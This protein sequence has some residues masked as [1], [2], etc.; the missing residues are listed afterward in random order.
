M[1]LKFI[2]LVLVVTLWGFRGSSA[3]KKSACSSGDPGSIPGSGRFPWRRDRLPNPVFL[4][5][6]G[7]SDGK[8]SACNAGNLG[9]IPGLGRFPAGGHSNPLQYSCLE[10]RH[11]QRCLAGYSPWG[12]KELDTTEPLS[13]H[14]A[15]SHLECP[16]SSGYL[17]AQIGFFEE[18]IDPMSL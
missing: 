12:R 13:T 16:R 7:G 9:L 6:P 17:S 14:R 1:K 11:W 2:V 10:N 18:T 8:E 4:N 15:Q 5:F 3:G